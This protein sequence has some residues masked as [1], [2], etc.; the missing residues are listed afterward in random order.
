MFLNSKDYDNTA[1]F[2]AALKAYNAD[3]GDAYT[4]KVKYDLDRDCDARDYFVNLLQLQKADAYLDTY[5]FPGFEDYTGPA[6]TFSVSYIDGFATTYAAGAPTTYQP[7]VTTIA[8]STQPL[9]SS[10]VLNQ[11]GIILDFGGT[12]FTATTNTSGVAAF[13]FTA[14]S[15]LTG[16]VVVT[17]RLAD[18]PS[19]AVALGYHALPVDTETYSLV[20]DAGY[21]FSI[22]TD[23]KIAVGDAN[24]DGVVAVQDLTDALTNFS[25]SYRNRFTKH[26][27]VTL[28]SLFY[29]QGVDGTLAYTLTPQGTDYTYGAANTTGQAK[30]LN[31]M[32]WQ[33]VTVDSDGN[34]AADITT[35][36]GSSQSLNGDGSFSG[37]IPIDAGF[38]T[39]VLAVFTMLEVNNTALIQSSD[40]AGLT[41]SIQSS[42]NRFEPGDTVVVNFADDA[43]DLADLEGSLISVA[44]YET[45]A[46]TGTPVAS[47]TAL[48]S[49]SNTASVNLAVPSTYDKDLFIQT[50]YA[51]YKVNNL[52]SE[53]Y[54]ADSALTVTDYI[55]TSVDTTYY[56]SGTQTITITI[57]MVGENTRSDYELGIN[58]VQGTGT[59]HTL[60]SANTA[61][62]TFT[63]T[64]TTGNLTGTASLVIKYNLAEA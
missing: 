33:I 20:D 40:H 54:L 21:G 2:I 58:I 26:A 45:N 35:I 41:A 56:T 60:A 5:P 15:T 64:P 16:D 23:D 44:G 59:V 14:P 31:R 61:D 10:I 39:G 36:L 7:G 47:T 22:T 57:A 1:A 37:T 6:P 9:S 42:T 19:N 18:A 17:S 48:I 62:S 49:A 8:I 24:E 12:E 28:G 46:L 63:F 38:E 55:T 34:P 52:I 3:E 43:N 11:V 30:G 50:S 53:E 4:A 13:S 27:Y 51:L 29:Y 25:N 32:K